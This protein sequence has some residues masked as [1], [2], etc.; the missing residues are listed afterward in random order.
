M[1]NGHIDPMFLHTCPS[2]QP[3]AIHTSHVIA[4]YVLEINIPSI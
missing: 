2:T 1:L 3:T 4:K